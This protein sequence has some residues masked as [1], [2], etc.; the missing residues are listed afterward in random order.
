VQL[1][2]SPTELKKL[3][4]LQAKRD[5]ALVQ[6]AAVVRSDFWTYAAPTATYGTDARS[7]TITPQPGVDIVRAVIVHPSEAVV[8]ADLG[9][10]EYAVTI[11]DAEGNVL[12]THEQVGIG[13]QAAKVDLAGLTA[14]QRA[15]LTIRIV[16]TRA[17]SD[18]DTL[19]SDSLLNDTVTLQVVQR[20]VR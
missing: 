14:A 17:V 2:R 9:L 7:Y 12:A 4:R 13:A 18:P 20:D 3:D 15:E 11:E 1:V 8:G 19:D 6:A 16:G 10:F 5:A